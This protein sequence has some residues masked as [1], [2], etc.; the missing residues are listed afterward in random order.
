MEQLTS[1][2][3]ANRRV[4]CILNRIGLAVGVSVLGVCQASRGVHVILQL[5]KI[6]IMQ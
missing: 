3:Y 4:T 1:D 6:K 5:L 2:T